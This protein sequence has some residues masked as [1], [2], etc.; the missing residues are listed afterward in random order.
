MIKDTT[1]RDTSILTDDDM[2]KQGFIF[3]ISS[4]DETYHAQTMEEILDVFV[5][6]RFEK[7]LVVIGD[8]RCVD[9]KNEGWAGRGYEN[10]WG[11]IYDNRITPIR[12][13]IHKY[14]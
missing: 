13:N 6:F 1:H 11:N 14:L 8:L 5:K 4:E 9:T 3:I 10:G 2:V 7:K 12:N